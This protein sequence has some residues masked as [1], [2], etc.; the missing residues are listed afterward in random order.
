M[1]ERETVVRWDDPAPGLT[2]LPTMSGL[3]Y[4]RKIASG[5]LPG[6]PIAAHFRMDLV[7]VEEGT[8]TFTC[9]PDESHYNPIGTVHGGLVCTLLDSALGCATQTTLPAGVGYT[10]V[11]IK[12]NFLRAVSKDSG[13]LRCIGRVI[14]PGRRMAFAEGE[15]RDKD[16]KVVATASSSLLVFPL[17]APGSEQTG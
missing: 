9:Q 11:E 16:D 14:K 17:A 5:E 10:S 7:E 15:V 1:T 2:A 4:L 12:V 13:P 6:A 3:D 8:V